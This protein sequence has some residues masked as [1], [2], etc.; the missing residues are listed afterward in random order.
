MINC[1]LKTWNMTYKNVL[2][3]IDGN[4]PLSGQSISNDFR[5]RALK[6]TL[7]FLKQ[8]RAFVTI[9][10]HLGRPKKRDLSL[11]TAPLALWYAHNGYDNVSV[12]EN[13]R[14]DPREKDQNNDYAQDL[15]KGFDF[16]INDAWG[17]IHRQ[18]TSITI[19]PT[20]F[21]TENRSIGFLVEQELSALTPLRNN[22]EHPFLVILGGCK[23][24]KIESLLS[25]ITWG[26][27]SHIIVLPGIAFTF[28]KALGIQTG[29]SLVLENYQELCKTIMHIALEK[30]IELMFP[31]DYLVAHNQKTAFFDAHAIP[32]KGIGIGI[33]PKTRALINEYLHNAK[34]LFLNGSLALEEYPESCVE[35]ERLLQEIAATKT[36]KIA[37][38]GD[39]IAHLEKAGLIHAFDWCS[40]GGGSTLSYISGASLKGLELLR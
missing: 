6:P 38:G 25:L 18:D 21:P 3:R 15:A 2:L 7:D 39:T 31:L 20:H 40:T 14:F 24:D 29:N 9:I 17:V 22:P 12:K 30:K 23:G 34:I 11:S 8:Q 4:V 26:K 19:L 1:R 33:G 10:T 36:K 13:V 35:F 37:G 32:E 5:L 27:V 28:L 16:F